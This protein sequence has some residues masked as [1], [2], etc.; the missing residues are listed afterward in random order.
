M[1]V[2]PRKGAALL[3]HLKEGVSAPKMRMNTRF[4]SRLKLSRVQNRDYPLLLLEFEPLEIHFFQSIAAI[5]LFNPEGLYL[6]EVQ[7][8]PDRLALQDHDGHQYCG[9]EKSDPWL[10][11]AQ[12]CGA[13]FLVLYLNLPANETLVRILVI[14]FPFGH[15]TRDTGPFLISEPEFRHALEDGTLATKAAAQIPQDQIPTAN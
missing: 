4:C 3:P 5:E 1:I 6:R 10:L 8:F 7:E 14:Q 13:W 2:N 12:T 11:A 15:V 9:V